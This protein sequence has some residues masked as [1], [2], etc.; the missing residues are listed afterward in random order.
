MRL[1]V[2]AFSLCV[3]TMCLVARVAEAISFSGTITE[4]IT[5]TD[6]PDYYVGQTAY[7]FYTYE[8]PTMDGDFGNAFYWFDHPESLPTL[9]GSLSLSAFCWHCDDGPIEKGWEDTHLTVS[10]GTVTAFHYFSQQGWANIGFWNDGFG[11]RTVSPSDPGGPVYLISGSVSFS[12][13]VQVPESATVLLA[14][15][16]LALLALTRQVLS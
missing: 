9:S 14:L 11:F 8:S 13:P 1:R 7:G 6:H 2:F 4:T 12:D 15:V 5:V 3:A 16:G 10:G